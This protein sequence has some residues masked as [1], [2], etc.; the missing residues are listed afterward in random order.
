MLKKLSNIVLLIIL[1]TMLGMTVPKIIENSFS[2]IS[3]QS[4][5]K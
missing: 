3:Q 5:I 1:I 2:A 4:M